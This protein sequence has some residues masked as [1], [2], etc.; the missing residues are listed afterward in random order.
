M[1]EARGQILSRL[2]RAL[3]RC[4]P[5][6]RSARIDRWLQDRITGPLPALGAQTV[7]TFV[8]QA[9]T[10]AAQ[11]LELNGLSEVVETLVRYWD[12]SASPRPL[13]AAP[14]PSLHRLPW[15]DDLPVTFRRATGEDE[16]GLMAAY[17]GIAETGSLVMLSGQT[18]PGLLNF[19][20]DHC[21]YLLERNRILAYPEQLWS[22]LREDRVPFPR[23]LSFITGPS[24]TADVEQRLQ[25]G[26]H[27]PRRVTIILV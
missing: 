14:H 5:R 12:D 25:L 4:D 2:G 7:Q 6:E 15:T 9:R 19:L 21:F 18:S 3:G 24:R 10:A 17:A 13:V 1:S 11:V 8:G 22:R 27:G 26:A 23:A 16:V 20:P